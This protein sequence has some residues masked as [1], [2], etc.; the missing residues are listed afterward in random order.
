M[1][2]FF[3]KKFLSCGLN[4]HRS[5]GNPVTS[6]AIDDDIGK[7][8][9]TQSQTYGITKRRGILNDAQVCAAQRFNQ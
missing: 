5:H 1:L 4:I 2:L 6:T 9:V 8:G 7:P 3:K